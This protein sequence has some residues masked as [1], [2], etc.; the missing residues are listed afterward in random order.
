MLGICTYYV[1]REKR[2]PL[3]A[4]NELSSLATSYPVPIAV[5]SFK[6]NLRQST[7]G[8]DLARYYSRCSTYRRL[9][10]WRC[11]RTYGKHTQHVEIAARDRD[12]PLLCGDMESF[13]AAPDIHFSARPSN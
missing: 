3:R 6:Q 10:Y 8:R 7:A 5:S 2:E 11:G 13:T 4:S 12:R 1:A 9:C